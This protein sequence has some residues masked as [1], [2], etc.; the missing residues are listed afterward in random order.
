MLLTFNL[1][2][3]RK[4]HYTNGYNEDAI[5]HQAFLRVCD[6]LGNASYA[7]AM[8]APSF[9]DYTDAVEAM[10]REPFVSYSI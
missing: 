4:I 5:A 8:K 6:E 10:D 9:G 3:I 7:N 2:E 1:I